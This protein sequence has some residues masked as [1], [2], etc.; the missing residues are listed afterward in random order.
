MKNE[1]D[2]KTKRIDLRVSPELKKRLKQLADDVNKT[3]SNLIQ[4]HLWNLVLRVPENFIR[5]PVCEVPMFD[6][7]V[8]GVGGFLGVKCKNGHSHLY[9]TS[10]NEFTDEKGMLK[11]YLD[12][13]S[14]INAFSMFDKNMFLDEKAELKKWVSLTNLL[15]PDY[16]LLK[17][18]EVVEYDEFLERLKVKIL[19]SYK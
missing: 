4:D 17:P 6:N 14:F 9:D 16:L 12:H 13:N 7:E 2:Y 8:L 11:G 5:C 10:N 18:A 15:S 3:T 1:K 19:K